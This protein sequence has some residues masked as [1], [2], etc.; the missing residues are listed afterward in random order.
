MNLSDEDGYA[1]GD[2]DA[3]QQAGIP[4]MYF[5]ATNWTLGDQD[6]YTQV[7]PQYGDQGA[8]IHTRYDNLQYLDQTFPGRVDQHLD[9]FVNVLHHILTEYRP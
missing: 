2:Y 5:E 8:I 9:L 6:G 3:F 7:D 4:W 1:T